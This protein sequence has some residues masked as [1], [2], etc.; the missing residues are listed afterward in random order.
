MLRQQ[1]STA[2]TNVSTHYTTS[3]S[4]DGFTS[5]I[6]QA[7]RGTDQS[8]SYTPDEGSWDKRDSLSATSGQGQPKSTLQ[9]ISGQ[10]TLPQ[11]QGIDNDV[12]PS[13]S[14]PEQ[15]VMQQVST[16]P[17]QRHTGRG[18]P[19][20]DNALHSQNAG[21]VNDT[22]RVLHGVR[23]VVTVPLQRGRCAETVTRPRNTGQESSG[24][25]SSK[26]QTRAKQGQKTLRANITIATLNINGGGTSQTRDN[27][28]HIDQL[29]RN[30]WIGI[31]AVQETHLH[32]PIVDSLHA[33]FY[34]RMHIINSSVPKQPNMM[35]VAV[36]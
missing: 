17:S 31:L 3:V 24:A 28:Q 12:P 11:S 13:S 7:G 35:G 36:V 27:W 10:I 22:L 14:H 16:P 8:V 30:K 1:S 20:A 33:Q 15:Y 4:T 18:L 5:G 19:R 6:P 21:D 2:T 25:S 9:R 29:L 34:Q 26:T 23:H 32:D